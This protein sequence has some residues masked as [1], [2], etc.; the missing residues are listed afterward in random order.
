[1][2]LLQAILAIGSLHVANGIS[3]AR[4]GLHHAEAVMICLVQAGFLRACSP[5]G[6][7][8]LVSQ[9]HMGRV[10]HWL[11]AAASCSLLHVC[12]VK[13]ERLSRR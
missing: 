3:V 8:A 2:A 12:S 13:R 4:H 7:E 6:V 5:T 1:M 9:I 10:P 11:T